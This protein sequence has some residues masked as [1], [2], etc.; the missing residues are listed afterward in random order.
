MTKIKQ[1]T[2][3]EAAAQ[4]H[5]TCGLNKRPFFFMV[6][7]GISHPPVP[8]AS[9]IIDDCKSQA[10]TPYEPPG[11]SQIGKYSYWI[12]KAYPSPVDRQGYL[13]RLIEESSV[14]HA[15][16]RLAHLL[17]SK[18]IAALAVTTNFD[19]FLSRAL[20]LFGVH[21][22]VCDHPDT[23]QRI[24]PEGGWLTLRAVTRSEGAAAFSPRS[25]EKT[26]RI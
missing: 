19:D 17:L 24:R 22:V 5:R 20:A 23:V 9:G 11:L 12:Q 26:L 8:L 16:L 3:A 10:R 13:R 7:A 18:K 25:C 2:L 14:S 6:G 21:A 1:I 4:I 15:N